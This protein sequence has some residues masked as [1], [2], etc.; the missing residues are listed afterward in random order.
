MFY[1]LFNYKNEKVMVLITIF[2]PISHG[3]KS[4]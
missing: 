3:Y 4:D 1:N 2:T